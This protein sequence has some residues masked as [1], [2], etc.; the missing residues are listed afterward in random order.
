MAQG[1]TALKT[2]CIEPGV[3]KIAGR[4]F[5]DCSNLE[6]VEIPSTVTKIGAKIFEGCPK[7]VIACEKGSAAEKYAQK[8]NLQLTYL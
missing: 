6:T 8:N 7:V 1:C 3:Q 4:V 2:V 5:K